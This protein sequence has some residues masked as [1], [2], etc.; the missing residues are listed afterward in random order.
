LARR[1]LMVGGGDS[2]EQHCLPSGESECGT[3]AWLGRGI[4]A[5]DEGIP[6]GEASLLRLAL[7]A[8]NPQWRARGLGVCHG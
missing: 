8:A 4:S 5:Y 7:P 2:R 3:A 6:L 1:S